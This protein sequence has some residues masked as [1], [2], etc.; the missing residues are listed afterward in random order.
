M[1]VPN[2]A[3]REA[4]ERICDLISQSADLFIAAIDEWPSDDHSDALIVLEHLTTAVLVT[5]LR[6]AHNQSPFLS[7]CNVAQT[8]Y[9]ILDDMMPEIIAGVADTLA[10]EF[11]LI[12]C[13]NKPVHADKPTAH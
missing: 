6:K 2:D 4:D 11:D 7:R 12:E 1:T 13:H 8:V 10:E 3:E 9:D 5:L